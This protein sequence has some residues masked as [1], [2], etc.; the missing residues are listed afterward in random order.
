MLRRSTCTETR[1]RP[2][3]LNAPF[4]SLFY[5]SQL[6]DLEFPIRPPWRGYRTLEVDKLKI[7]PRAKRIEFNVPV[8]GFPHNQDD[9][10]KQMPARGKE[11]VRG[12]VHRVM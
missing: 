11:M 3:S 5:D 1:T 9:K 4:F 12:A 2:S 7:K 6:Y 8:D 10:H